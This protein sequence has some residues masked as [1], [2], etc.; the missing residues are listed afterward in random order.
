M[1]IE[2]ERKFLVTHD[3]WRENSAGSLYCQ[4]Y[5]VRDPRT[6]V[7]VRIAKGKGILTIKGEVTNL[8]RPEYE[9]EIPLQEAREMLEL[10][11]GDQII[12]KNRYKFIVRT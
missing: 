10:W 5:L 7:R 4:G 8:S 11:C 9:Y 12:E 1:G 6:T 3:Q 2:I